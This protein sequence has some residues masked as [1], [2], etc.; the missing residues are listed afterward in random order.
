MPRIKMQKGYQNEYKVIQTVLPTQAGEKTIKIYVRRKKGNH[1][2]PFINLHFTHKDQT[3]NGKKHKLLLTPHEADTTLLEGTF[4]ISDDLTNIFGKEKE[5]ELNPLLLGT[6]T[7]T[8]ER[9]RIDLT[10]SIDQ[11]KKIQSNKNTKKYNFIVPRPL[12][13]ALMG[14]SY[15]AGL[16]TGAYD[17]SNAD[18]E[19]G[20]YRSSISGFERIVRHLR[21]DYRIKHINTSYSGAQVLSGQQWNKNVSALVH[22]D[23]DDHIIAGSQLRQVDQWLNGDELDYMIISAGGNDMYEKWSG[24]SGLSLMIQKIIT[25]IRKLDRPAINDRIKKG[26]ATLDKG[27]SGFFVHLSR[28]TSYLNTKV[29]LNTYPDLTK[30]EHGKFANPKKKDGEKAKKY[31]TYS[32]EEMKFLYNALFKPLNEMIQKH[33]YFN[34]NCTVNDVMRLNKSITFHGLPSKDPWFNRFRDVDWKDQKSKNRPG[35][36]QAFHPTAEGQYQIYFKTLQL[37]FK[38]AMQPKHFYQYESDVLLPQSGL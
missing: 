30:D 14:D 1:N 8:W 21:Q 19:P 24:N 31:N 27:Y 15:A 37:T 33:A 3:K 28:H 26:L 36:S 11:K 4:I 7:Q 23:D 25:N 10:V 2:I 13:I 34:N 38:K 20:A 18:D 22:I 29:I 5:I 17:L 12:R 16:G 6:A 35:R 32:K 9:K